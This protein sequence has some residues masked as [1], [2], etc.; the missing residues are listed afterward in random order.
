LSYFVACRCSMA[1]MLP[2][3][4]HQSVS[5]TMAG[6]L[7]LEPAAVA[8]GQEIHEKKLCRESS[9]AGCESFDCFLS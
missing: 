6:H 7:A 3:R 5:P 9:I 8:K 1:A 2:G 4:K